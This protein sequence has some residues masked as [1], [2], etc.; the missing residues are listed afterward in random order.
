MFWARM[1]QK[2]QGLLPSRA[3]RLN[4]AWPIFFLMMKKKKRALQIKGT[5][6]GAQLNSYGMARM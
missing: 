4:D 2:G 1:Q 3:N 5:S 6:Q